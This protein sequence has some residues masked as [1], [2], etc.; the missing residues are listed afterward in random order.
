MGP[1]ERGRVA[2]PGP[3]LRRAVVN[4]VRSRGRRRVVEVREAQRRHG[5][6]RGARQHDEHAADHDEVWQA[7]LRLPRR[8]REAIVLR[9]Y[10]DLSEAET[11]EVLGVS[12]GT[13]KSQ[14]SRGMDRLRALMGGPSPAG[15][16]A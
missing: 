4:Q 5:D 1:W 8:Q 16:E 12:V 2:D 11:A 15:G 14:V 9:Y 7:I 10:E 13:V 3:Y 6:L